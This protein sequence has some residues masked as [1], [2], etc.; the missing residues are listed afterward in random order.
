MVLKFA[1]I[2]DFELLS[3]LADCGNTYNAYYIRYKIGKYE[4]WN[5]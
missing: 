4:K 1:P 3:N 5:E 2:E